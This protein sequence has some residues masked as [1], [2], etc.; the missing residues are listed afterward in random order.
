VTVTC[1]PHRLGAPVFLVPEHRNTVL[2]LHPVVTRLASVTLTLVI[3]TSLTASPATADTHVTFSDINGSRVAAAANALAEHDIVKGC[4]TDQ[5]CPERPLRRDQFAT[6]LV[7][8]RQ[9]LADTSAVETE[10]PAL[11]SA[12]ERVVDLS[13][14]PFRDVANNVHVNNIALLAIDGVT[15]GCDED[16]FCPDSLVMRGQLATLLAELFDLPETDEEFFDDLDGHTH[17]NGVNRLA[18]AGIVLS[19]DTSLTAFCAS[20]PV[21]RADVAVYVARAMGLSPQ[22]R[23]APLDQR[24]EEQAAID[25]AKAERAAMWDALAQCESRGDWTYGPHST[26]GSR[27]YHGGLQFHPNTWLRHRDDN[28]PRYA[29]RATREQQIEV[30]ERVLASQGWGA[31]PSCSRTLGFR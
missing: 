15:R 6:I 7:N 14:I 24:R 20:S 28:M 18:A 2:R 31:W 22:A 25:A 11:P 5:Y 8:A 26:W 30:G 13:A 9:W 23:L 3:A 1:A 17:K 29:F 10:Q 4:D 12:I 27:L 21:S 19:C 16:L